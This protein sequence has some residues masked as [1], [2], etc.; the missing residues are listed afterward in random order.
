MKSILRRSLAASS[1]ALALAAH[2]AVWT[3]DPAHTV[4]SFAV[5]HMMISTVRGT[6]NTFEGKA[7]FDE[8]QPDTF[9]VEASA[10]AASIDTRVEQRD[11]HLKSADFFDVEKFP[12]LTFKSKQVAKIGDGHYTMTGDLTIRDVTK[13]VTF[14]VTGFQGTITDPQGHVRTAATA[15]TTINR[16][17][18]GLHWNKALEGGGVLVGDDVTITLDVELVKQEQS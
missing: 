14:D 8:K 15:T 9:T 18:F 11:K 12:K 6:F 13:A 10:D 4:V 1:L 7:T 2:A 5:K 3:V 17:D 16:E